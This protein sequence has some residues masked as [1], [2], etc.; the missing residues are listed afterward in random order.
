MTRSSN[1]RPLTEQEAWEARIA[2]AARG[3]RDQFMTGL[4][5]SIELKKFCIEKAIDANKS[6]TRP[7]EVISREFHKFLM[8]E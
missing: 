6:D 5:K 2:M 1:E 4:L 3:E 8:E 7:V